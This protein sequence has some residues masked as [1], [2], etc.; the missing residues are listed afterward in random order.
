VPIKYDDDDP[1]RCRVEFMLP[2]A[3]GAEQ[4]WLVGDFNEWSTSD[5]PM[6][7]GTDGSLTTVLWLERGRSYRYRYY[8]GGDRWEN[9]W[10]ADSYVD[11]EFGGADSLVEVPNQ[12]GTAPAKRKATTKKAATKR[13]APGKKAA[14][15]NDDGAQS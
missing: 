1:Q 9:D 3:A 7:M 4:A 11:N 15:K 6:H 14:A 2:A 12:N 10:E 5:T 8:L 13:K